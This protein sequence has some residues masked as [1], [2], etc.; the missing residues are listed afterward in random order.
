[1]ESPN[2][3]HHLLWQW[4]WLDGITWFRLDII[5]HYPP[6]GHLPSSIDDHGSLP[7]ML[8]SSM[9]LSVANCCDV[10]SSTRDVESLAM[11]PLMRHHHLRVRTIDGQITLEKAASAFRRYWAWV[12]DCWFRQSNRHDS[13][14][15][16]LLRG[17]D[18][19]DLLRPNEHHRLITRCSLPHQTD[20][21]HTVPDFVMVIFDSDITP[22]PETFADKAR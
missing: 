21:N 18:R 12:R 22:S 14:C 2:G 3:C 13:W 19:S 11:I 5:I 16:K 20:T 6:L 9:T 10:M 17:V 7:V 1:M 8:G 4:C 15:R